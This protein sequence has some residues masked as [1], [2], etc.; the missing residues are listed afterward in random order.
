MILDQTKFPFKYFLS[1]IEALEKEDALSS[2][3]IAKAIGSCTSDASEVAR[4]LS[5]L[6]HYGKIVS[7]TGNWRIIRKKEDSDPPS[8][9]FRVK[10]IQQFLS[11]IE[12]LID[13]SQ[14]IEELAK[15]TS[16][17]RDEIEEILSCLEIISEK[18]YVYL[19]GSGPRQQWTLKPWPLNFA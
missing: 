13:E 1:V 6:T 3:Q 15:V 9:N 8:K 14:S 10:Y 18:G 17:G 12:A 2:W 19:Q 4:M 5:Y 11:T 7:N 16:L